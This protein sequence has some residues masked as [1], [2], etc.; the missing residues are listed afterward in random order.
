MKLVF[1]SL[2]LLF[3]SQPAFSQ[4]NINEDA[5]VSQMIERHI[6]INRATQDL[7][8]WKV[9]LIATSDRTKVME[10]KGEFLSRYPQIKVD[11]DYSAPYY[12]L[13]AGAFLTK[14][15]AANLKYRIRYDYPDA[16]ITKDQV[17]KADL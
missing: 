2:I 6:Q 12:K 5:A 1:L 11:W 10:M 14:L 4:V 3:A 16:Y 17:R 9:Q 15:E 8:G 7:E 13:K